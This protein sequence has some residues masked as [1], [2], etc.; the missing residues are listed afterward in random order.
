MGGLTIDM[1][2][3]W[4]HGIGPGVGGLSSYDGVMNPI[5]TIAKQ[6]NISTVSTW[7]SPSN[8]TETYYW[9]KNP[10]TPFNASRVTTLMPLIE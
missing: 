1:G 2:A 6:S 7:N 5:Y 3:S 8:T 10:G 4:I 9:W